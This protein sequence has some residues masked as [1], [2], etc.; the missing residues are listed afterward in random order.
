MPHTYYPVANAVTAG[1][2]HFQDESPTPEREA[3]GLPADATVFGAFNDHYKIDPPT[4]LSL[5]PSN[6]NFTAHP[7]LFLFITRLLA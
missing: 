2:K 7:L 6:P 4:S 3:M 1:L 5:L